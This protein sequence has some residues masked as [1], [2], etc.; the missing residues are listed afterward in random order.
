MPMVHLTT[1]ETISIYKRLMHDPAT[2]EVWQPVFGKDFGGMAQ[3]NNKT[4]KKG[5][6]LFSS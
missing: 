3:G 2:V 6:T 1:G 5:P 4:D